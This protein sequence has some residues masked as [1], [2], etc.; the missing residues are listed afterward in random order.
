[1]EDLG[2]IQAACPDASQWEPRLYLA[3]RC[4]VVEDADR[5]LGF[6]VAREA[7]P[8]ESEILN[9]GVVPSARR[10]GLAKALLSDLIGPDSGTWFLEVRASNR[11]ARSLYQSFGFQQVGERKYYYENPCES[12]IVMKMV[13]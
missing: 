1:L 6:V 13:S 9:L 8:G 2:R 10:Q 7:A 3:Y 4:L 5:T 12:A 11:A